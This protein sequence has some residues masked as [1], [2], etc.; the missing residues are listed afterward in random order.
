MAA[1]S[2]RTV[3]KPCEKSGGVE[4]VF[5]PADLAVLVGDER[6]GEGAADV[7]ADHVR[8]SASS[9][10]DP[11]GPDDVPRTTMSGGHAH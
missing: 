8:H 10:A 4:G 3:R 11:E 5:V 2:S 7:D 6:V 9:A 1:S